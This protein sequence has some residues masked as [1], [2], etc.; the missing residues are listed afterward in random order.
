[1]LADPVRLIIVLVVIGVVLYLV[2][3]AL[4]IDA[5]IK[6]IIHIVVVLCVCLWLL[7]AFAIL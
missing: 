1:M 4:P 2:Q 3:T 6:R 5:T 7:R